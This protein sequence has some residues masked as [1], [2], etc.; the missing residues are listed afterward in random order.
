[1]ARRGVIAGGW[2]FRPRRPGGVE[3]GAGAISGK[4]FARLGGRRPTQ[5]FKGPASTPRTLRGASGGFTPTGRASSAFRRGNVPGTPPSRRR[6]GRLITLRGQ[7]LR[8]RG[9]ATRALRAPTQGAGTLGAIT[10]STFITSAHLA[11]TGGATPVAPE[12]ALAVLGAVTRA[13]R[14]EGSTGSARLSA[15]PSGLGGQGA[16]AL[17]ATF[18]PTRRAAVGRCAR[19]T[20]LNKVFILGRGGAIRLAGAARR[21]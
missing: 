20:A 3:S 6:F 7:A 16:L 9:R 14:L 11:G 17:I 15:R 2:P 13:A 1:M 21:G 8:S 18:I 5:T 19:R 10:G 12:E 4:G